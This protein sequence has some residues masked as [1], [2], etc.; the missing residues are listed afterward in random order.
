MLRQDQKTAHEAPLGSLQLTLSV[1]ATYRLPVR[2]KGVPYHT[3]IRMLEQCGAC[4]FDIPR[5]EPCVPVLWDSH[6]SCFLIECSI[7]FP[8]RC[9]TY[10][11]PRDWAVFVENRNDPDPRTLK[12]ITVH[13]DCFNLFMKESTFKDKISQLFALAHWTQP[14]A[15]VSS[16]YLDPRTNVQ[17][18]IALAAETYNIPLLKSMPF[19]IADLIRN[20]S[21]T[22]IIWRFASVLDRIERLSTPSLNQLDDISLHKIGSWERDTSPTILANPARGFIRLTIDF[23]GLK[24]IEQLEGRPKPHPKSSDALAYVVESEECLKN[25]TV[26]FKDGL[27]HLNLPPG[28]TQVKIW[29]R[30]CPPNLMEC[31]GFQKISKEVYDLPFK[32]MNTIDPQ[33]CTGITFFL[34]GGLVDLHAHTSAKPNPLETFKRMRLFAQRYCTWAYLPLPRGDTIQAFGKQR[35]RHPIM[36]YE[37]VS[38]YLFRTTLCGDIGIGQSHAGEKRDTLLGTGPDLTLIHH[39]FVDIREGHLFGTCSDVQS[40]PEFR[41]HEPLSEAP[42]EPGFYSSVP[43]DNVTRVEVFEDKLNQFCRGIIFE[44]AT[45]AQRAVG[46]CRF[47]LDPVV[48]VT[49]PSHICLTTFQDNRV[50]GSLPWTTMRVKF[51]S[52]STHSHCNDETEWQCFI[53]KGT[54]EC[55][56]NRCQVNIKVITDHDWCEG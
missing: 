13:A 29:D 49:D 15:A 51:S 43:L 36:E 2:P 28:P 26:D 19:E 53:L 34:N 21:K 41:P 6:S 14:W 44:Y 52:S 32:L 20:H 33:K 10:T 45:G 16:L 35:R 5:G 46:E 54:L 39:P 4:G 12:S 18:G 50:K 8:H 1:M 40:R 38:R 42:F 48:T 3:R 37:G 25:I 27:A 31:H 56:F 23:Q 17:R 11:T 55:W 24:R 7:P 30:P 47:G 9:V 22:D